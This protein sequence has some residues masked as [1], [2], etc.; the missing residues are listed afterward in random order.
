MCVIF[1]FATLQIRDRKLEYIMEILKRAKSSYYSSF[2]DVCLKV[3]EGKLS[4][5]KKN[6]SQ[7]Y[8]STISQS[9]L[10]TQPSNTHL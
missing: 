5:K 1:L 4:K 2:L 9:Q 8:N 3:D 6:Y 7:I 10:E